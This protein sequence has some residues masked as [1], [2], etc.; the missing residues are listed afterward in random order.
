MSSL[1]GNGRRSHQLRDRRPA[2]RGVVARA[3]DRLRR[4]L[5]PGT[6]QDGVVAHAPPVPIRE[7]FRRFWPDARPFRRWIAFGIL[8]LVLVPLIQTAEIWM[9][10]IVIDDV[11][12]P[13][14]LAALIPIALAY[15]GLTLLGGL[16]S[17]GDEYVTTM[18][19]ERFL[20]RLRSRVYAHVQ[21]LSMDQLDNRRLGDLV[22][23]LTSDIQAIESFVLTG[24][25]AALSSVARIVLFA[26]AL[27]VLDWR[28][29][30]VSLIVAPIFW[31]AAK[32]FARLIKTASREKRRRSGSLS[33]VAEEGLANAALVQAY[34][35]EDLQLERFRRENRGIL[36]AELA[37]ARIY[38]LFTPLVSLIE[39][40]GALVVIALGTWAVTAGD[41]SLGGLLVFLTYL[42]QL[43][44]PVRD[45]GDLGNTIFAASAGAE[46]V[47]ELLEERP[48][49][50]EPPA[51]RELG[52]AQGALGLDEVTF[53]YPGAERPAIEGLTLRVAPG[54]TVALVGESGAGKST[55]A[56]LLLRFFDPQSGSVRLDGIDLRELRLR[57]L[58]DNLALLLQEILILDGSVRENIAFGRE[59]ASEAEVLAAARAAGADEFIR[60]LPD[61]Y[62]TTVGQRG[63]RLSGGQR[64]RIAIARALVRDAP[65]LILDEPTT[66]L[67]AHAAERLR[68]PLRELI[69]GP[70]T[71][72]ISHNLLTVCDAD[73]ICVLDSGRLVQSGTH[74]Q[75][76]SEGGIYAGLWE[77]ATRE[78][79]AASAGS[80]SH[81]ERAGVLA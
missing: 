51:P 24:V 18:V 73:R 30:L 6:A 50:T 39:L 1:A 70:T 8:L 58:R 53:T 35:R 4:F 81:P 63:R 49:V 64:Q 72:V 48:S 38:G 41:L 5:S 19:G 54:E 57:S 56:K 9:F 69:G 55:V 12:V 22:S 25:S 7:I 32:R 43:F 74:D 16:I 77:R 29:A 42:T 2:K 26:G 27:F 11:V 47:I 37:S 23:R 52:R 67:D 17:F 60:G 45:L 34:G 76:L 68:Q 79:S 10:K 3:T 20:L 80:D 15:L 62:E 65:V 13:G 66:G 59:G 71:I 36:E 33:A 40:V 78:R 75:L 44:K 31:L 21:G 61:G 46:R 28:L 14:A